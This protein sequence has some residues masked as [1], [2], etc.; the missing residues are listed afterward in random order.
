MFTNNK[1]SNSLGLIGIVICVLLFEALGTF[2]I[3]S[4]TQDSIKNIF[5]SECDCGILGCSAYLTTHSFN[6][7]Q[8]LCEPQIK[9]NAVLKDTVANK[10]FTYTAIII[11]LFFLNLILLLAILMYVRGIP[12]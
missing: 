6:E 10:F 4:V 2:L 3:V 1:G 11:I 7:L 12:Q 8:T 5:T 9:D